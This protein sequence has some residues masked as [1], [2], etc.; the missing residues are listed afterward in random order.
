MPMFRGLKTVPTEPEQS[1]AVDQS[2]VKEQAS[3]TLIVDSGDV[4]L[5]YLVDVLDAASDLCFTAVSLDEKT[6]STVPPE[7]TQKIDELSN[8]VSCAR[9]M[10]S[11]TKTWMSQSAH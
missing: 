11:D 10:L 1:A 9:L 8:I 4:A 7:L 6:R 3:F 2:C 5:S